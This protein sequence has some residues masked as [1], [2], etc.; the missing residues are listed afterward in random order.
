MTANL[1]Q[2][3]PTNKTKDEVNSD[4]TKEKK[5][6]DEIGV[7]EKKKYDHVVVEEHQYG[8]WKVFL[9]DKPQETVSDRVPRFYMDVYS[10]SPVL[11]LAMTGSWF[12][13]SLES[14]ITMYLTNDMLRAIEAGLAQNKPVVWAVIKALASR[15]LCSGLL[16][17]I[18]SQ[19]CCVSFSPQCG[20]LAYQ[21]L[22]TGDVEY[23]EEELWNAFL[24]L[25]CGLGNLFAAVLELFVI[26]KSTNIP[27]SYIFLILHFVHSFLRDFLGT[28]RRSRECMSYSW[29]NNTGYVRVKALESLVS[30]YY[31]QDV[32][33]GDLADWI[34]DA[35]LKGAWA[36][37][38]ILPTGFP[39]HFFEGGVGPLGDMLKTML[40]D[41]PMA[42]CLVM[43]VLGSAES[44]SMAN[45]AILH[46]SLSTLRRT[47]SRFD[48]NLGTIRH[49][50]M[51]IFGS[52]S[53]LCFS[54]LGRQ[55]SVNALQDIN[56]TIP[57]GSVVVVVGENGS[58][59]S[60]LIKILS[61]LNTPTTGSFLIDGK[62]ADEYEPHDLRQASVILSQDSQLYP[63]SFA[64]NIGLGCVNL[65]SDAS[66]V[67]E[68]AEKGG[69]MEFISK[70]EA[71]L[72]TV[73]DPLE[74][75]SPRKDRIPD[76][77]DHPL[78]KIVN[79]S[80]KSIDI[81]GGERQKLLA[82]RAFMRLHSGKVNFIAVDEPSSALDAAAELHLFN[83]L[84]AAREGKTV[85]FV[86]HRFGHLTKYA[87]MI[88]CMKEG[89]IV[90]SGTHSELIQKAD[91][92]Y[93]R[94]YRIQADAFSE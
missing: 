85:V 21:K 67:Q 31:R 32:I 72:D 69:A 55:G 88:L 59:K 28:F 9:C 47:T 15:A 44:L 3:K 84:L 90:E 42:L 51:A 94:L 89:R 54:Y 76:D 4:V 75:A 68:A 34:L 37:L 45:I 52:F 64:E 16:S 87:D 22:A 65:K 40:D 91:G 83:G 13:E 12:W 6:M 41:G 24:S 77:D 8:V 74:F 11:F 71:G 26:L 10:L 35:E 30:S 36:K 62:P 20:I 48:G 29:I 27:Y 33:C 81:S 5:D 18:S 19:R 66:L 73:L 7:P 38:E 86:T 57:A 92:E 80:P 63:L 46:T 23:E 61:C 58:G 78:T 70:L 17:Y 14:A 50:T 1:P 53:D 93:A 39:W 79:N 56:L 82:A 43:A 2:E 49:Y 25:H 60:T